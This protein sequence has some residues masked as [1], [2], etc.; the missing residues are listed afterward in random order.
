MSSSLT[1]GT[2]GGPVGQPPA[3]PG[4]RC[5]IAWYYQWRDQFLAHASRAFDV[6]QRNQKQARLARENARL[7]IPVGELTPEFKKNAEGGQPDPAG[8]APGHLA[9]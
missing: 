3:L 7:K 1:Y 2:V 8:V 5:L 4:S 6:Q 9:R